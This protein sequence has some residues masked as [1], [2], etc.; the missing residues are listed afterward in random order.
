MK[1]EI[2]KNINPYEIVAGNPAKLIRKRFD[3]KLIY[4]LLAYKWWNM[5]EE[6]LLQLGSL[7]REPITFLKKLENEKITNSL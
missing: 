7:I 3:E 5:K 6:N 4:K 2:K 1:N